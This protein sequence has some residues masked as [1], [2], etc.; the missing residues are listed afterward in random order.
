MS[1]PAATAASSGPLASLTA[2][3]PHADTAPPPPPLP[4]PTTATTTGSSNRAA[5]A[6]APR[7]SPAANLRQ[8]SASDGDC[9]VYTSD[10]SAAAAAAVA[11]L[12]PSPPLISGVP[13]ASDASPGLAPE[14]TAAYSPAALTIGGKES[15]ASSGTTGSTPVLVE[16]PVV[17]DSCGASGKAFGADAQR[18]ARGSEED[19]EAP[20]VVAC[21]TV[22][23]EVP[24][25]GD[26]EEG[27][28]A[29]VCP[30]E[31]GVHGWGGG[32]GRGEGKRE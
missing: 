13:T 3:P 9:V 7:P 5:P 22:D 31:E 18:G 26:E 17:G 12:S 15:R 28:A 2:R 10:G 11:L 6:W 27:G 25:S 19:D 8:P 1:P 30:E 14:P 23:G 24:L 4:P 16:V 21:G 20:I 29:V 32:R